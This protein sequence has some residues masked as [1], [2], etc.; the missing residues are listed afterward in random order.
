MLVRDGVDDRRPYP[1]RCQVG[2]FA[3]SGMV[4]DEPPRRG[5]DA[6]EHVR[7]GLQ[8][9]GTVLGVHHDEVEIGG[10]DD[11]RDCGVA[12]GEP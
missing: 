6:P 9:G 7:D 12:D 4:V 8:A 10:R 1:W 2:A 5:F 11:L 3:P